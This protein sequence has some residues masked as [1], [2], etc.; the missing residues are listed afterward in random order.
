ML[1]SKRFCPLLV[2]GNRLGS[3][4]CFAA[5]CTSARVE[6]RALHFPSGVAVAV[7]WANGCGPH[8]HKSVVAASGTR[9]PSPTNPSPKF[10]PHHHDISHQRVS[11]IGR[12]IHGQFAQGAWRHP[13]I[14]LTSTR[15][16]PRA[17]IQMLP[18]RIVRT[19]AL[20]NALAG[21]RRAPI[22][23]R[24]GY[25]PTQYSDKKVLDEKYPDPPSLTEAE[26]PGMVRDI[27]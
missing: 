4:F 14:D 21:A 23:Q 25:L 9:T 6:S 27:N 3:F 7:V 19:S 10:R 13:H 24:R 11:A 2:T 20:R 15:T 5:G 16:D 18:Q 1:V 26:D 17:T 12:S 8:L 22:V